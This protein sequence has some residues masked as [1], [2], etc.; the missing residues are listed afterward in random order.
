MAFGKLNLSC[1]HCPRCHWYRVFSKIRKKLQKVQTYPISHSA[2]A[3][4]FSLAHRTVLHVNNCRFYPRDDPTPCTILRVSWVLKFSK[5]QINLYSVRKGI[6]SSGW[7]WTLNVILINM[8]PYL[9]FDSCYSRNMVIDTLPR[10]PGWPEY[11]MGFLRLLTQLK[12]KQKRFWSSSIL[13]YL[14]F[15]RIKQKYKLKFENHNVNSKP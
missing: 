6:L 3:V 13:V 10:R 9:S 15:L 4:H 1:W 11:T 2:L 7:R 12:Q 14:L 8:S 5:N